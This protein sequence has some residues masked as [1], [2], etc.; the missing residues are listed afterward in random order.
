MLSWGW[1][2]GVALQWEFLNNQR[3]APAMIKCPHCEELITSVSIQ[4]LDGKV[5]GRTRWACIG[6]TCPRCSK[7]ISVQIDPVALKTDIL[8]GVEELLKRR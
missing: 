2:A 8:N 3:K 7:L 5:A 1:V 6:Y 4:A